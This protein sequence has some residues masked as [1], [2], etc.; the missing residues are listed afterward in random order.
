MRATRRSLIAAAGAAAALLP[1]LRRSPADSIAALPANKAFSPMPVTYLN[2][3]S[4]AARVKISLIDNRLRISASV[5]NDMQD[6]D[7]LIE[8]LP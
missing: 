3:A 6:I 7:R 1:W 4:T 8:A 5:F 2:S